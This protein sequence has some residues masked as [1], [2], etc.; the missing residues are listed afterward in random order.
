MPF[1]AWLPRSTK[2]EETVYS[3]IEVDASRS[4]TDVSNQTET[5]TVARWPAGPQ[6]IANAS[7]WFIA[8]LLLLLMPVAFVGEYAAQE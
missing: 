3:S 5:F 7:L 8:D 2:K 1:P 4:D 6:H